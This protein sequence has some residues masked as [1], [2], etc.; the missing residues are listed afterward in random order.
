MFY[1]LVIIYHDAYFVNIERNEK[2]TSKMRYSFFHIKFM[3]YP[4][5]CI[6]I[7]PEGSSAVYSLK[8]TVCAEPLPKED[9]N[10][11]VKLLPNDK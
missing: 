5:T 6:E 2:S 8:L 4:N 11:D 10:D 9:L 3:P 1:T 7:V